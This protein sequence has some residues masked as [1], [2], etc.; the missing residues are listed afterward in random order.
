MET[1]NIVEQQDT[2]QVQVEGTVSIS[3]D[4]IRQWYNKYCVNNPQL[5]VGKLL[6]KKGL[7]SDT[8]MDYE[9]THN[10]EYMEDLQN[11]LVFFKKEGVN[12]IESCGDFCQYNDN[13]LVLFHD[14]Y[15]DWVFSLHACMGNHDYLRIYHK[16]KSGDLTQEQCEQMWQHN[17]AQFQG[18]NLHYF[19]S[20]YKDKL[21][22]WYEE[23]GD[24]YAFISIDY[25]YSTGMVWDDV[26]R[27]WN[28]LDYSNQYVQQMTEYIE[29]TPY[30][31]SREENFDY[32]FYNPQVLIWLKNLIEA[33][34]KKRV[35]LFMHHFLPNKAG[36]TFDD[37]KHLRIWPVPT[38]DAIKNKYYSGSNTVCGIT[39]WFLNKLLLNNK[40]IIFFSGHSHYGWKEQEDM[41]S[42][43]YNV[44]QPLGNE[45][46]PLVDDLNSLTFT[47]YDYCL[48]YTVG[49]STDDCAAS[50]HLPSLAKPVAKDGRTLYGASEG[51]VMDVYE[52]KVVIRCIRFK[53]DGSDKYTNETIKTITVSVLND[54][55]PVVEP[56]EPETQKGIK[57]VFHNNTGQDIRFSGKFQMYMQEVDT[58]LDLYLC[59]P[60]NGDGGYPHWTE[61]KYELHKSESM[62]FE[63]STVE[64]YIGDG[65]IVHHTT[66]DIS[67]YYGRHFRVADTAEWPQGIPAIKLGVYAL[68]RESNEPSTGPAMIHAVP[69]P[70]VNSL[71][72]EGGVY[73]IYL[74]KIK[75][76]ATFDTS[77]AEVPYSDKDKYK[78]VIM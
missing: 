27:G 57:I 60:S 73:H 38:S 72:K 59:P 36:D 32:Q 65:T 11:A 25:G 24:I 26:V 7:I 48:Y 74:D 4:T 67:N 10:S 29:D 54:S 12:S 22:Y 50:I 34:P 21:S 28:L 43:N 15:R 41:V 19:G 69:L 62:E 78:Y 61:N 56:K 16:R 55:S 18:N 45:V 33:N 14:A 51:A 17:I 39:F 31:R 8:H 44:N 35:F 3:K 49:H 2:I 46:T 42:R 71:I 58:E 30:D 63:F 53:E 13:D 66:E 77:W 75:D 68:N 47:Q 76:N 6:C 20:T 9:D 52:D 23:N 70:D 64:H 1:G 37:Y 5:S 40:N